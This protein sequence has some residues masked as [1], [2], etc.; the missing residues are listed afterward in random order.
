MQV[1]PQQMSDASLCEEILPRLCLTEVPNKQ[2]SKD[3]VESARSAL[4]CF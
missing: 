3:D 1:C 4:R 2:V